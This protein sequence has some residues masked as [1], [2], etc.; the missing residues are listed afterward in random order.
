MGFFSRLRTL[1]TASFGRIQGNTHQEQLEAYYRHQADAYDEFREHLLHGRRPLL[2][3]LPLEKGQTVIELGAGTGW[4]AEALGEKLAWCQSYTMVDLCRPLLAKARQR[5]ERLRWSN[6]TIVEADAADFRSDQPVDVVLCSY[7]LTMMPNWF[8]VVDGAHQLLRAG[9]VFAATDFYVSDRD[10]A[11]GL[12]RHSAWQRWFWP[13]CFAW[14]HVWLSPE[15]LPYLQRRFETQ[16]V[17]EHLGTMPFM[18][19]MRA[20]YYVFVGSKRPTD[21]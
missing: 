2:A 10:P 21:S 6:V 5:R 4:M 1:A 15:H 20:P 7:C 19:G 9:G 11:P 14:H 18:A 3:A 16:H 17:S 12:I 8:T 13:A